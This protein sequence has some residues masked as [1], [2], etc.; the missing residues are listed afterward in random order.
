MDLISVDPGLRAC[1]VAVFRESVLSRALFVVSP[2]R[3]A[4][5]GAAWVAMAWAVAQAVAAESWTS[6]VVEFPQ[7][8]DG[9]SHEVDR[10]DLS[11]LT[12]VAGAVALVLSAKASVLWTPVPREWKGQVPKDVHGRRILS[13]LTPAETYRVEWPKAERFRH[14]VTDA[15]GLGLRRIGR[16]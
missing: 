12:A 3:S 16:L 11:E 15:I 5:G 7:Q 14:N 13:R 6:A 9:E 2:E 8:Y 10:R 1:G 4:R